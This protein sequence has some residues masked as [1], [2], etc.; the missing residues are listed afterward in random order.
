MREQRYRVNSRDGSRLA[1]KSSPIHALSLGGIPSRDRFRQTYEPLTFELFRLK[2]VANAGDRYD[3]AGALRRRFDLL[4]Q[5][6]DEAVE[7]VQV[8]L[9]GSPD[10]IPKF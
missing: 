9:I 3:V 8:P 2:P 7:H 4:L 1:K 5:P 6:V 10:R